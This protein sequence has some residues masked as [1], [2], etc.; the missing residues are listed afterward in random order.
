MFIRG[1][2]LALVITSIGAA[3]A[4]ER[5][6]SEYEYDQ[7][8]NTKSVNQDLSGAA[9]SIDTVSPGTV[10]QNQIV[11]VVIAGVGLRGAQLN[12]AD[13][14][15]SFSNAQSS[16][17]ELTFSML[18]SPNALEGSSQVSV[19]TG[20]G[21]AFAN[22][23]ILTELPDLR[24]SPIPVVIKTGS[25]LNLDVSLSKGD[26]IDHDIN[27]NSENSS[28]VATSLTS[29]S[30]AQGQIQPN[31]AIQL[32]AAQAGRTRLNFESTTLGNYSYDLTV[33]D[34]EYPLVPGEQQIIYGHSIG[35]NKLF[36]PPP[37][38]LI[39]IGPIINEVK[40]NKLFDDN[41]IPPQSIFLANHVGLLKG[42]IFDELS[43]NAIA[44]GV[45]NQT[46]TVTGIG[47][48]SIDDASLFPDAGVTVHDLV[49]DPS[50]QSLTFMV[51]V[52]NEVELSTRQL[53]LSASGIKV[54]AR[55]L[56]VD[57]IYIG[58]ALPVV[59]SVAP[60][61][62]N[63]GDIS[64]VTVLGRNFDTVNAI[65]FD[66]EDDLAFSKPIINSQGT[67]LTFNLHVIGFALLGPRVLTLESLLGDGV[68][69]NVDASTVHI[70]DRPPRSITPVLSAAVGVVKENDAVVQPTSASSYSKL[71]GIHRG[72]LLTKL[73][74][75]SRSQGSSVMLSLQGRGLNT[76]T[77][78]EFQPAQGIVVG[79]FAHSVDGTTATL[80]IDIAADA[81]PSTRQIKLSN[82]GNF[83]I[84]ELGADR[85]EV[86]LPKPQI[87]SIAPLQ[88]EQGA[89]GLEI[90]IRGN[91]LNN[92]S[93]ISFNPATDISVTNVVVNA[94]GSEVA[95]TINVEAAAITGP[96]VVSVM[97]PGGLTELTPM[98][99]NTV[100]IVEQI[101]GTVS[102]VISDAVGLIKEATPVT[103]TEE[104]NVLSGSVGI[105]KQITL[106]PVQPN[107]LAVAQ[108][109]GV[110]RG[111]IAELI[112]PQSLA[113]G[114]VTQTIVITG[115][116]LDDVTT[117]S[118]V[119]PDG[120][121]L[122]GPA[123]IANDGSS[124]TFTADVATDAAQTL[125][126][127]Q[128]ETDAATIPFASLDN[129]LL[130]ITGLEP[131]ISSIEPIQQV[132]GA[133]FVL[134]VR[135]INFVDVQS[136]QAT[137]STGMTFATPNVSAD[138]R[139]LTV[140]VFISITAATE[141]KVISVTSSAGQ[142]T[143][144]AIPANTFTVISE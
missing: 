104:R 102:P 64:T 17:S 37:P 71:V 21:T 62:F 126:R 31:Q 85:F 73:M 50:G 86:T 110:T 30:F 130:R 78:V 122:N 27:V 39:E 136:V 98:V 2:L 81:N 116:N 105:I 79:N 144:A 36:T 132:R 7:I 55:T 29:F 87:S 35:V 109:V 60:I 67:Q 125:R 3:Y 58:G 6:F 8:G 16:E 114:S 139:S 128:L 138:G 75:A 14:Y 137:P 49:V 23:V 133:S 54:P 117:L 68:P 91:L 10:R 45:S 118:T 74:P 103:E 24:I 28:V 66:N 82:G 141:Q 53:R 47:L 127:V 101:T 115:R 88:I 123:I 20:L 93:S 121:T 12:N 90:L 33:T 89:T 107:E 52:E 65:S 129:A 22:F 95:A 76:V 106:P 80:Q 46:V 97:T 61:Y 51:D 43:P 70:Q 63:R 40:I 59:N 84:A 99:T 96:R 41:T 134:T 44:G 124:I 34:D 135:G 111:P 113:I 108:Q 25:T 9:P 32:V 142:T 56:L 72:A 57:R 83:L 48:Q 120:V 143:S 119:P 112:A 100:A 140:Q 5:V 94:D 26:V 42:A 4:E 15:F 92:A 1:I 69:I 18:V 11:Q 77:M 13:G 38:E 131:E 19:T